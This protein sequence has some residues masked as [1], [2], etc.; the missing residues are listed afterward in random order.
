VAQEVSPPCPLR[1]A[2]I[3]GGL[4]LGGSTTFLCNLAGELVR[5]RIPV[6]VLSFELHNP[7]TADFKRLNIPVLCQDDRRAIFEDRLRAVLLELRRF[8][9]T[10]VVASLAASSFEV[11]RYLPAGV[12]RVGAVQSHDP[13]A[14]NTVRFYAEQVG[15]M[16]A[17]SRTI[18]QTLAAMPEF[19]RVPIGYL[20]YGVPVPEPPDNPKPDGRLPLRI[21]YLGRLDQEQKRVRLFPEILRQLQASGV[22]FHWTIAG[23]G[24]DGPFL[25]SVMKSPGPRQTI[26]FPGRILYG[27]VPQL[28]A[29][30]DVFLL[31]S[32][33][34]GLPLSLLEAMGHGLVPV[35]SDLP[36]GIR[37]LVH[38]GTGRRIAPD[39]IAGYAGAI[40][41]LH[42]HRDEMRC[43]SQAAREKVRSEFSV[44]AMTER[45]LSV[46]QRPAQL[47]IRW[48]D[49]W[50]FKPILASPDK[51]R[52]SPPVRVLRRQLLRLRLQP[53]LRQSGSP[54]P[55]RR[56]GQEPRS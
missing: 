23:D 39:N 43:L 51:W 48:P 42:H 27:D 29:D 55:M 41:W 54:Y 38:E 5:R 35:V 24:P 32:D 21:V 22:P 10:V 34:E 19:A 37:E 33:Y 12:L 28:L 50:T 20:P 11:L 44:A 45:W 46:L 15:L 52:F 49:R 4:K 13:G 17:V 36:S 16:A 53:R 40:V 18:E 31:A 56:E 1:L 25:Q 3:S 26:S 14:Y 30:H 2:L 7:L 47:D 6:E 9:P 8:K